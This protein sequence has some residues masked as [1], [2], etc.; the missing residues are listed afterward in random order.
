MSFLSLL[1][2]SIWVAGFALPNRD[3]HPA[4]NAKLL[5]APPITFHLQYRR[6]RLSAML[7]LVTDDTLHKFII[8][9]FFAR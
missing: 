9:T 5:G 6:A 4:R 7:H 1:Q 3:L 8:S 2:D